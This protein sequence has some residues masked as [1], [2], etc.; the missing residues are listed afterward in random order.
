MFQQ[1]VNNDIS[2]KT[3]VGYHI[4]SYIKEMNPPGTFALYSGCTSG[5]AAEQGHYQQCLWFHKV[6]CVAIHK[7]PRGDSAQTPR[8]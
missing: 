7:G 5:T 8:E 6:Q 3:S 4:P 2:M 1:N